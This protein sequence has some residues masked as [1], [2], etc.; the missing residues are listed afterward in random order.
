VPRLPRRVLV[1]LAV[2]V[3]LCG[4]GALTF[5]F[6]TTTATSRP[7]VGAPQ[8]KPGPVVLV[9]G[10]GGNT[11]S[12]DEL[13]SH[14]RAAGRAAAV[15]HLP[16]D[17]RGDLRAQAKALAAFAL[18]TKG[19]APS[20]DVVGYSAG[21][22]VTRLWIRDFGGRPI[23]RRVVTLGSP[24]HGTRVAGL[25]QAFVA[26]SCPTACQQLT[27][28]SDLLTD[29][30]NS[31]ET[32]DGPQWTALWTDRDSV[33]TP[34]DSGHLVGAINVRLQAICTDE[35]TT[36]GGL[37]EA[38]LVVGIVLRVIAVPPF[39]PPSAADCAPLRTLGGL[40]S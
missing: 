24:H 9:P 18:K 12:L 6:D 22:I 27:P 17:G 35:S 28:D 2:V 16:G 36:H 39:T 23:V 32:P 7:F 3:A 10:Y 33:V 5:V 11:G 30:D 37:P 19:R 4:I 21:G 29:L 20:V 15:F 26:D 1:V 14:I 8:D 31:D 40:R 38:P 25:A 34:A 13:A